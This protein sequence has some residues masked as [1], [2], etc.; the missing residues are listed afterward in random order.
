[1]K[2]S[3]IEK[4]ITFYLM[5]K[6]NSSKGPIHFRSIMPGEGGGG[7]RGRSFRNPVVFLAPRIISPNFSD[8]NFSFGVSVDYII[9]I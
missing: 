6:E 2:V 3:F 9:H 1:M 7:G 8:F 4:I 5:V